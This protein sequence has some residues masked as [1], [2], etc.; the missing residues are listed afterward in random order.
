MRQFII[1][2]TP[3]M[4]FKIK[5]VNRSIT[6]ALQSKINQKTKPVGSLGELEKLAVQIGLIQG[7]LTPQLVNP[8]IVVFAGDHGLAKEGVS[9]YPQDVTWQMVLNF[10][11]GGAAI[12]V[13]ARQNG[14]DLTAVDAGVNHDFGSIEHPSFRS[15]KIGFGTKNSLLEPAM[16]D[17][18]CRSAIEKGAGLTEEIYSSGTNIIG[19]GE[20]GIGNTSAA[21]LLMSLLTDN[22]VE[23][24]T[25][26]GT[27]VEG[28]AL[29][30]KTAVLKQVLENRSKRVGTAN[31]AISC[32][33]YVGGFEMAMMCGSMLKAAEKGMVLM[34]DGFISSSVFLCAQHMY[35]EIRDYAIFCHKSEERGHEK[36][37]SEIGSTGQVL[38]L[39]MC[40]GEGTGC[41]AAWP[42]I[43]SAVLILN[44]MASF[45][46]AGVKNRQKE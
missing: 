18:E 27:G 20:M 45:E 5:V 14:I 23:E 46:E 8:H 44:R 29:Q 16:S 10:L 30:R 41:A 39:G 13:L 17:A 4:N 38:D 34:I 31:D 25:G 1:E 42:I 37:L 19:F 35:P 11:N 2:M 43:Q 15:E 3:V 7:T 22:P 26:R 21:S 40:L 24:C 36:L 32:L 6:D 12:N 33:R 28:A 9:A